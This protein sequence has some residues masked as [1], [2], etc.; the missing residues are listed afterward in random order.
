MANLVGSR[1][2][3]SSYRGA[4]APSGF[5]EVFTS[6]FGE[7][8]P[9]A[10]SL[11]YEAGSGSIAS[12]TTHVQ[13]TWITAEGVSLPSVDAAV[14]VATGSGAVQVV[15]PA[16]PSNG[17]T[18]IGW[19]IY[20]NTSA[21]TKLN[22]AGTSPATTT[23]N[24]SSGVVTGLLLSN[25]TV[26]VTGIG[27]GAAV[28]SVDAS[29]N[30]SPLPQIGPQA[31]ADYDF[32]VPNTASKFKVQK[33]VGFS[34]PDGTAETPKITLSA[35][36]DCIEPLYPGA[37]P[38][39]SAYTQ[40]S[41]APGT[42]MVLNGTLYVATQTGSQNTA[43]SFIGAAAFNTTKGA[44]TTDGSVIWT[45]LGKAC[46]VRAHFAN[47]SASSTLAPVAQEYDLFVF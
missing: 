30:Q 43:A 39:S 25:T 29:G 1:G 36:M 2:Y 5:Y 27:T 3:N 38:G 33:P 8:A 46:L 20:S 23:F 15:Q 13:V 14:N 31:S 12:S 35:N 37:T 45:S 21:T 34:R 9:A 4:N 40:Q 7:P 26:L 10:P 32:I 41:V 6:D 11:T 44:T 16:V 28:P 22:S 42:Y 24:T 17:A 18:I 47:V 19:Q